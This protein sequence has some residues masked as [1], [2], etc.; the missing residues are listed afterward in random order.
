M[1]FDR[2][3]WDAVLFDMDGV[4]TQTAKVHA[5][6]W[7]EMFDRYLK[8]RS[9][10]TGEEFV[11][12]QIATDYR[13]YVDGR[14]RYDGVRE[15]LHSRRIELPEGE[16]SDP[17][18]RETICGLG[19]RKNDLVLELLRTGSVETYECSVKWARHLRKIGVKTAVVSA[20]KNCDLTL[21]AAGI[22]DLFDC[23]VDGHVAA[24]LDLAG[25]PAPDSFL[26]AARELEVDPSRAVVV[27]DAI[28]GVQA[29]KAGGFGLVIGVDRHHDPEGLRQAGADI[30]VEDLG[31]FGC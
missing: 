31:E 29:G 12:F 1:E 14:L 27:E 15:F 24:R 4:L 10:R 11:P 18:D 8:Q 21:K 2:E 25:K 3:K 9:E 13:T 19:N 5:A 7:R 6:A 20:S 17:P 28:S 22:A 23:R 26:Q 16:P 30:V